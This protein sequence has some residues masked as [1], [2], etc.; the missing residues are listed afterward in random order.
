MKSFN[1]NFTKSVSNVYLCKYSSCYIYHL[2]KCKLQFVFI[3]VTVLLYIVNPATGQRKSSVAYCYN[4][5]HNFANTYHK[6]MN[7]ASF[8]CQIFI[9]K[10]LYYIMSDNHGDI[11]SWTSSK[12]N[13]KKNHKCSHT[14]QLPNNINIYKIRRELLFLW[15]FQPQSR[16]F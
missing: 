8:Y 6:N 14:F 7:E 2:D 9:I 5:N 15:F 1:Q 13:R 16:L 10:K 12:T 11:I 3:L 4:K